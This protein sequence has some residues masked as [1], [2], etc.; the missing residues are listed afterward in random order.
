M[1]FLLLLLGIN[2]EAK[3]F[4]PGMILVCE[5]NS[6][7][8]IVEVLDASHQSARITYFSEGT[9]YLDAVTPY[10]E[11]GYGVDIALMRSPPFQV[12]IDLNLKQARIPRSGAPIPCLLSQPIER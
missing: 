4:E 7:K 3:I 9:L 10:A 2:T 8:L 11:S 1:I 12:L 6:K 5:G